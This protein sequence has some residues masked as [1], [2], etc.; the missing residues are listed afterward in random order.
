M[1]AKY[2]RENDFWEKSLVDSDDTLGVKTFDKIVLLHTVS[3]INAFMCFMQKFK[4]AAKIEGK[5]FMGNVT[6]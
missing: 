5:L 4:M 1:A 3:E 6:G 2:D